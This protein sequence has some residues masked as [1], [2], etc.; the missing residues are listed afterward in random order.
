[1]TSRMNSCLQ[2]SAVLGCVTKRKDRDIILRPGAGL[3]KP[4]VTQNALGKASQKG[5]RGAAKGW[6]CSLE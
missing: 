4:L 1:M 5:N 2:V 3:V 6:N